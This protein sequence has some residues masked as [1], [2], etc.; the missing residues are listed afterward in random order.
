V[1]VVFLR[2]VRSLPITTTGAYYPL[3]SLPIGAVSAALIVFLLK[4]PGQPTSSK[5]MLA[6]IRELDLF[7][8]AI[9]IPS[10]VCLLLALQWGG[11]TYPWNSSIIISLFTGFGALIL[12]FTYTQVK[13]GDR[14]TLP[15]RILAQRTVAASLCYMV[16]FGAAFFSLIIYL[17]L[18]FQSVKG[19]SAMK[20]GIDIL[21]LLLATVMSSN[22][23][24]GLITAVGYYTPF[25]IFATTLFCI[26]SGLVSTYTTTMSFGRWFGFQI[27]AGAGVGVGF[28]TPLLA[29]QTVL[30]LE[31]VAIGTACAMFFQSLGGA[32][33]IAVSQTV[34]QNGVI[35]GTRKFAPALDPDVLLKGGA[36]EIREKLAKIGMQDQLP[37]A[38]QAYMTGLTATFR[39][40][41][42]CTA[43]AVVAACFIEWRSIKEEKV[44]TK[45]GSK[46][47]LVDTA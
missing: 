1:A 9:L 31:D 5:S 25:I 13:L 10:V 6:R 40:T 32:V 47:T 35:R 20:S 33:F 18:Y 11:S 7:G 2:Q 21:P 4:I 19:A 27:L 30:P 46:G 43:A 14:A 42:A 36:T 17:P 24:G 12:I 22:I 28:Q 44:K 8:A 39:V 37:G 23:F 45:Q 38:L 34:F 16:M 26:G 41:V 15:P 29:V 3:C